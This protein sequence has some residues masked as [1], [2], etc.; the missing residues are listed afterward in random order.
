M[1]VPSIKPS[2][3]TLIHRASG[4]QDTTG[5][6]PPTAFA[7]RRE[8]MTS[9]SAQT[10]KSWQ[11]TRIP[12]LDGWRA[13]SIALVLIAHGVMCRGF[14]F[15]SSDQIFWTLGGDLGV[16]A[17]FIISGFLITRLMLQEQE[18]TGSINLRNFYIRRALRI[19]PVYFVFLGV[20]LALQLAGDFP[21]PRTAG[22]WLK[23]LTFTTNFGREFDGISDHL[24][25]LAVEEQFYLMWPTLFVLLRGG[26]RH[27]ILLVALGLPLVIAPLVRTIVY[28]HW[29]MG[30]AAPLF[31]RWSYFATFD[32]L[33]MG[34]VAA[35]LVT[36]RRAAVENW[37]KARSWLVLTGAVM[38]IVG[39]YYLRGS[40]LLARL[41]V[42]FGDSLQELA[43]TLLLIQSVLF[44]TFGPYPLLNTSLLCRVGVLSYSLYIW[45]QLFFVE[46]AV[47]GWGTGWWISFP[48]VVALVFAV[49]AA[50]YYGLEAPLMKLRARFKA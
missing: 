41:T 36:F 31:A 14:P 32:A 10:A 8:I 9:S 47:S 7:Q 38:V 23:N 16:R 1:G 2:A 6:C 24:W 25:S 35:F 37:M 4:A 49:A 22:I 44:P 39:L 34:C 48:W 5:H 18:K 45:Q 20:L 29:D 40:Y 50:S 3:S 15:P 19:F 42:P 26:M 33:A 46:S 28:L 11:G 13:I 21:F 43:M 17:F 30:V 12:S 27:R